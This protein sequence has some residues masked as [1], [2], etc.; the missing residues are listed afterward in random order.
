[1][2]NKSLK[3]TEKVKKEKEDMEYFE[4]SGNLKT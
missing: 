3:E 4:F 2:V 1:M